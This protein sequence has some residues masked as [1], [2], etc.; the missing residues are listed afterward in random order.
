MNPTL[1]KAV[2]FLGLALS[3]LPLLPWPMFLAAGAMPPPGGWAS[4]GFFG[5]FVLFTM[6]Y[7]LAFV[8]AVK[9]SKRSGP[10]AIVS[11]LPF[12][13]FV[14]LGIVSGALAELLGG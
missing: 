9:V 2:R 7:P 6:A 5:L 1:S 3:A 4:Q 14:I 10:L 11:V 13:M 8:A 12:A